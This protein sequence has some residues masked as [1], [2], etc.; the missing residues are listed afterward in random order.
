ML[1][2]ETSF[3]SGKVG[4]AFSLDG[5][6]DH[7]I[8]PHNSNLNPTN[9]SVGAWIK[10]KNTG[11]YQILIDKGH[12][13]G[14]SSG[15][16]AQI[17]PD[18]KIDFCYGNGSLDYSGACALSTSTLTDDAWHHVAGTLD[19]ATI[20]I[21]IDG[22][23]EDSPVYS[24]TP[25]SNGQDVYMGAAW[26]GEP[27][28]FSGLIDEVQIFSRSL[29]NEE[30]AA[31]HGAGSSGVCIPADTK[32]EQ[33]TF[34]DQTGVA[35]NTVFESN[36]ITVAGINAS[37]PISITGGEYSINGGAYT[38]AA[39]TVENGQ[40][41]KVR[42]TSSSSHSTTTNATLTIGG[43]S[44]TFSVTTIL[45]HL[46]T[47][48]KTGTGEGMVTPSTGSLT[49]TGNTGSG[50]YSSGTLV[51]LTAQASAGSVI[52]SFTGCGS[53]SGNICEVVMT[54]AR[55]VTASFRVVSA[56]KL[57]SP[58]GGSIAT[59]SSHTIQW[60]APAQATRF[61]LKY[62]IDGGLT[63]KP[64][65]PRT[66]TGSSHEWTVPLQTKNRKKCLVK[67][68]GYDD[69]NKKVGSDV[70]DPFA[71]HVIQV[72]SPNGGEGLISGSSFPVTWK[73]STPA[74]DVASVTILYS[75]NNGITWKPAGTVSLNPG[76]YDWTPNVS[77]T[78]TS[79]KIKVILKDED[80]VSLG[81]DVSD[82]VFTI[83]AEK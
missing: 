63:W 37:S 4:Q 38:L 51:T 58:G 50:S 66:I 60:E 45:Q 25:Q 47:V 56:I 16:V 39:G 11:G 75:S 64:V 15:W 49:W 9:I 52:E 53:S 55:N 1:I 42:Q 83:N 82:A 18:D 78:K 36:D 77:N 70:S 32:P 80:G 31:I 73:T 30:I 7:V 6:D 34:T 26:W 69:S 62:S 74:R 8:M 33:F 13:S 27:R 19:G 21:Y 48:T 61:S 20:K 14:N 57:L 59:G 72:T 10:A 68:I 3:A 28:F 81:N 65:V 79:C 46:L 23:L 41:V 44:D 29:S 35:L 43:V 17:R 40:T 76:T 24:G 12:G 22:I 5:V 71:I 2:H 54:S 67:V